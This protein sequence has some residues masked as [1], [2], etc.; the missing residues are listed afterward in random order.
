M[1]SWKPP[2]SYGELVAEFRED[3]AYVERAAKTVK[4]VIEQTIG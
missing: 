2:K 3:L 4:S 1:G